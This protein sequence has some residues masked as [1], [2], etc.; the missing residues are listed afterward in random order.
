MTFLISELIFI[1]LQFI[2]FIPL[3]VVWKNDCKNIGKD[4]LAVS[5]KERFLYWVI[6]FPLWIIPIMWL[7]K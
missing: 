4:R 2:L 7:L 3:Y 1:A 5:L 6:L